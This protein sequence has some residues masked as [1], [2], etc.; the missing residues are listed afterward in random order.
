[1]NF[2]SQQIADLV[3]GDIEGDK[4]VEVNF[5]SKIE[6]VDGE[7]INKKLRFSK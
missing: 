4:N 5:F 6:T 3:N 1:M 7:I 2:N